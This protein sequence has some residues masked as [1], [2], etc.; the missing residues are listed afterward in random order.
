MRSLPSAFER[1]ALEHRLPRH[2]GLRG[3]RPASASRPATNG[4]ALVVTRPD[5]AAGRGRKLTPPPVADTARALGLELD[6][7]EIVNTPDAARAAGRDRADVLVLCAFGALVKEPLARLGGV[8]RLGLE[9][10]EAQLARAVAIGGG[11]SL[12][13]RPA[14]SARDHELRA[15]VAAGQ[16]AQDRGGEGRCAEEGGAPAL[17]V[18]QAASSSRRIRIASWRWSRGVRSRIRTPSRWSISCWITRASSPRLTTTCAPFRRRARTRTWIGRSTSTW[19]P[20]G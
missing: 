10:V 1:A 8:H 12:R 3:R 13:P 5:R 16:A 18:R 14:R 19:T 6:Q 17:R 15:V 20:A 7:P 2:L 9:E 11:V 4:P